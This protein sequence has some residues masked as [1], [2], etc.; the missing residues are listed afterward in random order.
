MILSPEFEGMS[1]HNVIDFGIVTEQLNNFEFLR[2]GQLDEAVLITGRPGVGK[3]TVFLQ[4]V[5]S[6][7][8][9]G[10][11]FAG[12]VSREVRVEGDRIGFEI[13]DLASGRKGWLAHVN[14]PVGPRVGKYRVNLSDLIEIGVGSI[15]RSLQQRGVEVVAVDEI[16]PME[17]TCPEFARVIKDVTNAG[18]TLLA[19]V[20]YRERDQILAM[21]DLKQKAKLFEVTLEN[22]QKIDHEIVEAVIAARKS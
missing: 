21:F 1:V 9:S 3:T 14:Q 12:F 20:H 10:V 6:L 19:T 15:Q 7:R 18:K 11:G 22:R 8:A 4:V 17:L 16:G 13:M 2:A 5:E